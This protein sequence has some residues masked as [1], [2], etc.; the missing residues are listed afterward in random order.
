M[1]LYS[2]ESNVLKNNHDFLTEI[3]NTF[4]NFKNYRK[5]Y[6]S[7]EK[8]EGENPIIKFLYFKVTKVFLRSFSI[9]LQFFFPFFLSVTHISYFFDVL[10][11]VWTTQWLPWA[12]G[13]GWHLMI[14]TSLIKFHW[15]L[16]VEELW[17]LKCMFGSRSTKTGPQVVWDCLV[18]C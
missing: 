10:F 13:H 11:Y 15:V 17:S 12:K 18:I 7:N 6:V 5:S 9:L 2:I 16:S 3:W 14:V 1:F 8:K 4:L